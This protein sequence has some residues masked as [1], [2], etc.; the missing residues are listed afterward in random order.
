MGMP[1]LSI[2]LHE[3]VKLLYY[4][5]CKDVVMIRIGTSGGI[6]VAAGTVVVTETAVNEMLKPQYDV[7]I[8]GNTVSR[9]TELDKKL[10]ED[11]LK[12]KQ[13]GDQFEVVKG[14]TM[15]ASDFYECQG[16]LDGAVCEYTEDDKMAYLKKAEEIGV[17]NIEM[18]ATC[19]AAM[20][21]KVGIP[22][23]V[24]CVTLLNRLKGDQ[25]STPK[26]ELKAMEMHPQKIVSR[27]IKNKLSK[28]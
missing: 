12:S 3:I 21:K 26:D 19:F 7:V 24:V 5:G 8:L 28:L 14:K 17:R 6:G 2:L 16:R 4:A 18:E 23:A 15:S 10:M 20:C 11:L 9:E 25:V 27:Y 1:S 22:G 13:E